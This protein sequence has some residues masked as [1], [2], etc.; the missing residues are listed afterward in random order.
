METKRPSFVESVLV[1]VCLLL[2]LGSLIIFGQLDPHIPILFSLMLL[3]FYGKIRGA[4]WDEIHEGIINGIKPGIIPIIIFLLIGVL[5]ATWILSGTIPTIMVYGFSLISGPIFV[6][7]VFLICGVVG[8]IVGSSFTTISTIGIAFL[9]IGHLLGIDNALTVGA[10]VSGAFLGNN[11]SPLSDTTNLAAAI[12]DVEL[13][14][15]IAFA[16][17]TAVPASL[18]SLVLYFFLGSQANAANLKEIQKLSATLA[19]HF[20]ISAVS[21]LPVVLL[22][23]CAQRKIPAIPTLLL[24]AAAATI[25][26]LIADPSLSLK[27]V[28][29]IMMTGFDAHTGSR[30]I[31]DLLSRGGLS[32]ML[33]SASLIILALALGGLLIRYEIIDT[34]IQRIKAW[35]NRPLKLILCTALGSIGVNVLVGEQY[36]SI[37]LPGETFKGT[38]TEYKLDRRYLTRTLADAGAAVN[39]LI[40]WGVSGT[41]IASTLQVP[42]LHY[43]PYAF[44]PLAAP[45]LTL[46]S[47]IFANRQKRNRQHLSKAAGSSGS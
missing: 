34:I 47:G 43:L 32:S 2:I 16:A 7:A 4:T 17:R 10:I 29:A 45:I 15:H 37:I 20:P 42:V 22:L 9:G 40:P 33:G 24:G 11:L 30:E 1:L 18:I 36:L 21:L 13:F 39:S 46:I 28:A 25:L 8:V 44:Y 31:D 41:F 12:G 14:P 3:L 6:P 5:V 27:K 19:A 38:F 26:G 35:V 23:V